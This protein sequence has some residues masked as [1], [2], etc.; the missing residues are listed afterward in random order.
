MQPDVGATDAAITAHVSELAALG[1]GYV[2]VAHLFYRHFM[3]DDALAKLAGPGWRVDAEVSWYSDRGY[4]GEYDTS[5]VETS[6][7]QE[8]YVEALTRQGDLTRRLHAA[9]YL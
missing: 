1:A 5:K 8:T 6:K 9:G 2:T 4:F 7:Q 3:D